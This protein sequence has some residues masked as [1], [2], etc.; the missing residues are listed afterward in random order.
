MLFAPWYYGH[1]PSYLGHLV[2]YWQQQRL[3]GR[4]S[5][6][7]MPTFLRVHQD[8]VELAEQS[9]PQTV[10]FVPLSER[11]Q[12]WLE[13]TRPNLVKAFVQY[14]LIV[15]YIR[16][17]QATQ[18]LLMHF[19]SCQIPLVLGLPSPCPISGI[20]FTPTLHYREFL[21]YSPN[22]KERRQHLKQRLFLS[23][24][25]AHPQFKT[26][27]CLDPMAVSFIARHFKQDAGVVHLPD[28]VAMPSSSENTASQLKTQLGI[29]SDRK[30][31]LAFGILADAR[32]GTRQLLE[33]LQQLKPEFCRKICVL[34]VGEPFPEGQAT[35]QSWLEPV[36]KSLR[37][38]VITQFG[39]VPESDVP[40][41]FELS[42]FVMAPYQKHPGMSG[43]VLLAA[44]AKKPILSSNYGLMGELVKQYGLGI[45]VDTTNPSGIAKGLTRLLS[46]PS[47]D[48]YNV[49]GMKTFVELNSPRKF[50]STIFQNI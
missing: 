20:Y 27:F 44:A 40:R 24:L 41:Y 43:I 19:D 37:V 14:K 12:I 8:L 16:K 23:R 49:E 18:C 39:Y 17:L 6:V 38:Q 1:H 9:K 7:V 45:G 34:L 30:V 47:A 42:D 35:I 26:L 10:N 2:R 3:Q 13:S 29:E 22:G 15:R 32:K 11:E 50:A 31:L 21:N 36:R 5:I 48:L 25:F 4:L 33:A 28:P 46:K